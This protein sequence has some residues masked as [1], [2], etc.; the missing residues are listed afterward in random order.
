MFRFSNFYFVRLLFRFTALSFFFEATALLS[1]SSPVAAADD[2]I[3]RRILDFVLPDTSGHQVAFSDFRDARVRVIVFLGT[4]CPVGNAYVPDIVEFQRRYRDQSVK[5]I[6]VN[7][8]LSD[9][10]ETI[11]KHIFDYKID[12]PILV[13]RQQTVADLFGVVRIPTAYVLDRRGTIR[14]AGRFDDRVGIGFQRETAM[15]SDLEEAV[16]EVLA[17]IKEV[18]VAQTKVEGCKITRQSRLP[19]DHSMTYAKDSAEILHK[20]CAGCHHAGTA[21]PFSLLTYQDARERAQMIREVVA[22]RRM[23]PWDADARFGKFENDL[24]LSQNEIDTLLAWVDEGGELGDAKDVPEPPKFA[25]GWQIGPPDLVF[26]MQEEFNV[27]AQGAVRYQYFVV[28]TNLDHDV[29][30]QAAEPRPGNRRVVHHIIVYMRKVGSTQK[31]GLPAIG[32]FAVGEEPVVMPVGTGIKIPKGYELIFEVHYTPNGKETSDRSE[33]GVILCKQPPERAVQ[34]GLAANV[35]FRIPPGDP[36]YEVQS[37]TMIHKETELLSLMPHMHVRGRDFKFTARFPDGKTE[38][39]LN[40]PNYEFQW[41]HRYRFAEPKRIPAG[42]WIDCVAHFDN[43]RE[44]PGNPDPTKTVTW[45]DQT[46]EE[47]MIG[48]FTYVDPLPAVKQET[49]SSRDSTR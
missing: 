34:S 33:M 18:S 12:F 35:I 21:A 10:E 13:D 6:G 14:Y 39:L 43:S 27:P 49:A 15:R 23:P 41:Q 2:V 22:D 19:K 46:W 30:V 37:S 3:E 29:W 7:A 26:Q 17:G 25:E 32:G 45:G 16:K 24:R 5:V 42:T 38:V 40:V 48:F 11:Q 44:N 31:K 28:P 4:E 1:E 47:M 8:M 36:Y 9:T 20:R